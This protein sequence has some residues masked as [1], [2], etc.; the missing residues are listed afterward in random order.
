[1]NKKNTNNKSISVLLCTYNGERYLREQMDSL[2]NQTYEN[3]KVY[4]R[5]D[6]STDSTLEIIDEYVRMYPGKVILMDSSHVGYPDCFWKLLEDVP[7]SDYY[8]FCDQDDV[9]MKE[10][11]ASAV[12]H[13]EDVADDKPGLFIHDYQNCDGDLNVMSEHKLGSVSKLNDMNILFYTYAS[14]F[15]MAINNAMR[16]LCLSQ[17]PVGKGLYHDEWI[18][19]NAHFYGTIVN[20]S[21]MLTKYRRHEN[22]FT[23]YGN[24]V[25]VLITN[26]LKREITGPEFNQKCN[27]IK[28]YTWTAR[29]QMPQKTNATWQ[30]LSGKGGRFKRFFYMY[31]LRPTWGGELALRL[32]FLIK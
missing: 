28:E 2:M 24:G 9:W 25:G 7:K 31:R 19:W 10:K 32:L 5:D 18:I 13:L 4:V 8:A 23:E 16:D 15:C 27:R 1:M 22:T 29:E 26:W 11:A 17:K 3:L 12:M 14:G 30:M 20:D 6:K 21:R